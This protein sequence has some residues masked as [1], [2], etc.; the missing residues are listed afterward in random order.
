MGV[1]RI[2]F[3][4]Y[5]LKRRASEGAPLFDPSVAGVTALTPA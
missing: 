3:V 4:V 5:R 2:F 1:S